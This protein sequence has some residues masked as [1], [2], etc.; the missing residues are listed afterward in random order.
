MKSGGFVSGSSHMMT[1][2]KQQGNQYAYTPTVHVEIPSKLD[3]G[4]CSLNDNLYNHEVIIKATFLYK[5]K[6]TKI[7][8]TKNTLNGLYIQALNSY[9]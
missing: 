4:I 6:L 7:K 9:W 1:N 8:E 3:A 5:C 2:R